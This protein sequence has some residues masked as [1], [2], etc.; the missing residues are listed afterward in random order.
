MGGGRSLVSVPG[1]SAGRRSKGARDRCSLANLHVVVRFWV[2]S[3]PFKVGASWPWAGRKECSSYV[4]NQSH[5]VE[6]VGACPRQRDHNVDRPGRAGLS[7]RREK[8]GPNNEAS[9]TPNER[10]RCVVR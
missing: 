6:R 10:D 4:K 8:V 9:Q 2:S 5:L 3:D 7:R 1:R